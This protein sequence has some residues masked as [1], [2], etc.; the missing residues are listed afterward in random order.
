MSRNRSKTGAIA[1]AIVADI[2][3]TTLL[4]QVSSIGGRFAAA[5]F[6]VALH[7]VPMLAGLKAT[8]GIRSRYERLGLRAV[9]LVV[10]FGGTLIFLFTELG[11]QLTRGMLGAEIS[12]KLVSELS[13]LSQCPAIAAG[14]LVLVAT[15]L[16]LWP[17]PEEHGPNR[18]IRNPEGGFEDSRP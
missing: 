2:V 10:C 9:L 16:R 11:R 18:R 8:I 6:L 4:V 15:C 1:I 13:P 14:E 12:S 3:I 17:R 7:V 5:G